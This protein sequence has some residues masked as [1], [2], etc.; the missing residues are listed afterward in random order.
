MCSCSN[1]VLLIIKFVFWS[2]VSAYSNGQWY[3]HSTQHGLDLR[4]EKTAGKPTETTTNDDFLVHMCRERIH[5]LD[6][7][8]LVK[9]C[10]KSLP[11][12]VHIYDRKLRTNPTFTRIPIKNIRESGEYSTF[13][14]KTFDNAGRPK[15]FGG[16]SFRVFINGTAGSLEPTVY[17]LNNGEYDVSFLIMDAGVY[18]VSIVLEGSLCSSYVN[19]PEDWFRKG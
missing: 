7:K 9:P 14:I 18:K 3:T 13:K 11:F 1:I 16:D 10:E 6:Y 19:P 12:G 5:R 15:T 8:Q 4:N 17:D 2:T